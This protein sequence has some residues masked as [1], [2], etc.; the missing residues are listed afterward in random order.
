MKQITL[1]EEGTLQRQQSKIFK[2][3]EKDVPEFVK[4]W[5]EVRK[6]TNWYETFYDL[7]SGKKSNKQLLFKLIGTQEPKELCG[8]FVTEGCINF[9]EHPNDMGYGRNKKLTCKSSHCSECWDSWVTRESSKAT[10]R[11]EKFR[12]ISQ[13]NGFRSC[14][15]V[16]VIGSP[17]KWLWNISFAKLKKTF[18]K[19]VKRAGIV[20]G[21]SVFHGFR[22]KDK[23]WYWSP[24]FH[25]IG[26][27]WVVDTKKIESNEGWVIKNK[28]IRKNSKQ[29]YNSFTYLLSHTAITK[30]IHS[31]SW[32][33]ELG[34][35]AKY[36]SELKPEVEE[37]NGDTCPYCSQYL[38][39]IDILGT[40]RPPPDKEWFGLF[41]PYKI[42]SVE[43]I[44]QML[45][46][47][48]WLKKKLERES[49]T[50]VGY[51]NK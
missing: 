33:G 26:Y 18:R 8:K 48:F 21:V 14:I 30:G 42:I 19:M 39:L 9:E 3:T 13:R 25:L 34:Y 4:Y 20:G 28:G 17:P 44:E 16:H 24:H 15:P 38:V 31:V 27:G 47:K 41:E 50:Y 1:F 35:R 37:S 32:F 46:R 36:S 45:D 7:M 6:I 51:I 11:I 10:K 2:V 12:T 43:T 49:R 22:L 29:V 23:T 40:D 5:N